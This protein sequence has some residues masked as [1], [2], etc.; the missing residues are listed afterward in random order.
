MSLPEFYSSLPAHSHFMKRNEAA[1]RLGIAR[2]SL[3]KLVRAGMLSLPIPVADVEAMANRPWL[4]VKEGQLTVLRTDA[5][6]E[7]HPGEDRRYIGFHVEH[8]RELLSETSLRWWRSTPEKVLDNELFAVTVSTIPVAV[9]RITGVAGRMFRGDEDAPRFSYEGELLSM[10]PSAHIRSGTG[11]AALATR[12]QQ[13]M[14]SRI[15]VASGGP[16]GYL[17]PTGSASLA[18]SASAAVS[19]PGR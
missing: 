8:D 19:S 10:W 16:I 6:A 1:A 5:R 14:G 3:D 2:A 15:A 9:Y 11:Y 13:I 17:S 7:A 12:V 4:S 18:G